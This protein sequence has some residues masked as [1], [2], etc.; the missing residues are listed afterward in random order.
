MDYGLWPLRTRNSLP[1]LQRQLVGLFGWGIGPS[2]A[3]MS[4]FLSCSVNISC[5][6]VGTC[7]PETVPGR[8]GI[9]VV[10]SLLWCCVVCYMSTRSTILHGVTSQKAVTFMFTASVL[11]VRRGAVRNHVHWIKVAHAGRLWAWYWTF[12]FHKWREFLKEMRKYQFSRRIFLLEVT[13]NEPSV[14]WT[15]INSDLHEE[16]KKAPPKNTNLI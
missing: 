10:R 4:Y 12:G 6:T 9:L 5:W 14:I 13:Y 7:H 8:T 15:H 1:K 16:K 3:D 2:L 11:V